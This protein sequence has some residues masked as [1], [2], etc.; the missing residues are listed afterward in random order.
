MEYIDDRDKNRRVSSILNGVGQW[1]LSSLHNVLKEIVKE[2]KPSPF[3]NG[4]K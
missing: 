2:S 4:Q 3:L 1:D